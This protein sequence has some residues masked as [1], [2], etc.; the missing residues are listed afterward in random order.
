MTLATGTAPGTP[1]SPV[2]F[3][4]D[5]YAEFLRV[6]RRDARHS[7]NLARRPQLGIVI[8][9]SAA[10]PGAA[11]AVYVEA[12]A[13]ELTGAEQERGIAIYSRR[14]QADGAGD[15]RVSVQL[16]GDAGPR[17]GDA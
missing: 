7:C 15:R 17:T 1:A 3:A 10:R 12:T 14:S 8:F 16:R 9:D 5:G 13:E 4:H 11:R 2:W 6:S